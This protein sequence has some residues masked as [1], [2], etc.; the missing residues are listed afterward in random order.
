MNAFTKMPVETVN[1]V[2][3]PSAHISVLRVTNYK[4]AMNNR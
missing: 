4:Y 3:T 2:W 1:T